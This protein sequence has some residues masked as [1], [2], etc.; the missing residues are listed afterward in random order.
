[1]NTYPIIKPA[2]AFIVYLACSGILLAAFI[3]IYVRV[4]PYREFE[5]I[6]KN[7]NAAAIALS[8]AVLGF[9][10]PLVS[11]IYY[12][13]SVPEMALWASIT[14]VVQLGVFLTLRHHAKQIEAGQT[15][16]AILLAALSI[17]AGLINAACIS[18]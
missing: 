14:G 12:T 3:F 9:T 8:G 6:K 5:L 10:A 18:H 15:A 17:A 13:L 1:M 7:N 2:L 4:T 11:S 16:P